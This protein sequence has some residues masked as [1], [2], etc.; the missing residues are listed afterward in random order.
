MNEF[1]KKINIILITIIIHLV[2]VVVLIFNKIGTVVKYE[3]TSA[4]V[5][6]NFLKEMSEKLE[7][8]IAEK[9]SDEINIEEYI[10]SLRNVGSSSYQSNI[11][12]QYSLGDNSLSEKE[13]KEKYETELLKEKY[14]DSY[15]DVKNRSYQDYL[16]ENNNTNKNQNYS[17]E[18]KSSNYSGHALVFVELENKKRGNIYVHVPVFTCKNG[19]KVIVDITIGSDGKVKTSK[20]ASVKSNS[21]DQECIINAAIEAANRS[22]FSSMVGAGTEKGKIIYT[23]IDQ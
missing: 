20:I 18:V 8:E 16:D 10:A 11:Q 21:Q 17:R 4:Y 23:F 22:T 15:R 9:K 3:E 14:G 12:S 1:K 13:L 5:E 6:L 19:G 2:V 7:K